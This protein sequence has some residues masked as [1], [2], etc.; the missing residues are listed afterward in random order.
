[1]NM[2]RIKGLL[3]YLTVL[4]LAAALAAPWAL[5]MLKPTQPVKTVILDKT[6][7]DTSYR[8]HKG[9]MWLLN[10]KKVGSGLGGGAYRYDKD[11]YGFYPGNDKVFRVRD[12]PADLGENGTDLLY[13]TDAY[14]VYEE[15]FTGAN[16]SG[17]RSKS[18]YGGMTREDAAKLRSYLAADRPS[19]LVA[20]FNTFGSPTEEAVREELYELL[21]VRWTG[22][23]GRYI[24]D[25]QEGGEA[26]GWAVD[27]YERQTGREWAFRG[28]GFLFVD[29]ADRVLV[30]EEGKDTGRGGLTIGFTGEGQA[31]TGL[32]G[33]YYYNYWFDV[34]EPLSGGRTLAE[35][36]LDATP[37]GLAKLAEQGIPAVFP[38]V[39]RGSSGPHATYYF[40]GDYADKG[41]VPGYYQ[42]EGLARLKSWLT[43]DRR[44]SEE[45]F[46]WK[47]Y[48]PLMD[49]VIRE[50][51]SRVEAFRPAPPPEPLV[52]GGVKLAARTS[53]Q[54]LQVYRSGSWA[55]YFV[56]GVNMGMARPGQ[57]FTELPRD[58]NVYYRWLEGIGSMNANTVR[59]YTLMPPEFY[60]A[61]L[62]YNASHGDR[63]LLL[64]Q[65]IWPEES[66]E[67]MNVLA[68]AYMAEYRKE[69]EA[70]VDAVHGR[71]DIPERKGRAYGKYEAD[72]SAYVLAYLVGRELEPDEV[73]GTDAKNA[74]YAFN[75]TYL[76][77]EG[78]S[79]SEAWLAASMDHALTYE[80]DRYGWQ[81]PVAL[82]SWP[83][84]DPMEHDSEWNP[85]GKKEL[86]F[87]DSAVIDIRHLKAGPGLR[88]GL[89]GAYHIYPNYP[90]F[91]NNEAQYDA[92][93][94]EEGR[95]R[96]GGYLQELM[97]AHTGYPA[98]V[99]EFGLATGMGNA[100]TSPDG[101]NHGGLT[102]EEQGRGIVRMMKAIRQEGYAGGVVFEWMDEW[103]KKTWVT[104]P[105][106]IPY[107]RHAVWHNMAD[108]EQNYGLL[109]MESLKPGPA[110]AA[111]DG[112]GA[113]RRL[114]LRGDA[115][116][117][118]MDVTL[119]EPYNP[120]RT[121][122]LLG[123]DTLDRARGERY[124]LDSRVEAPSAM[125]FTVVIRGAGNSK[126]L[127]IPSYN[128]TN[129]K[130]SPGVSEQGRFEEMK[131]LI[132][133]MR[134]ARDGRV[135]PMDYEAS[136]DLRYGTLDDSTHQWYAEGN[137]VHVR[138]P[139]GRLNVTDPSR[140]T[141][142]DDPGRYTDIPGRDV[143]RTAASDGVAVSA[144]LR[145]P[146]MPDLLGALPDTG[147][148]EP[149]VLPWKPWD[150][151]L[152]R[153]RLKGSVP[154][155]RDY[156]GTLP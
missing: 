40:S 54:M 79:P 135:F 14:G 101:Y 118:Y 26:P 12:L 138:I 65:E 20:E 112:K 104:E 116:Y 58:V 95:L 126:L 127:V 37:E 124:Y 68:P 147:S 32:K 23:I 149:L 78:A 45:A 152:Y 151:P 41:T 142:L 10:H 155:I 153:E 113:V 70:A 36:K 47:V 120:E 46:F 33:S 123:I 56:K 8:E 89:F 91:M 73:R 106:M 51:H 18:L 83:T 115:S 86:E 75:G 44:G 150:R 114:E 130:F 82:V 129:L 60:R 156:F 38:A 146:G 57:W 96:Y 49:G 31:L 125:E 140:G 29:D 107:D 121:E 17:N 141:V 98:L 110:G 19:T 139:W 84:L 35:Y 102:E 3:P 85:Q 148:H 81:H 53:G 111:L 63:P 88:T 39:I 103:A 143:L 77:T 4:L 1:M 90:D 2:K 131:T 134:V 43:P 145:S 108:P 28:P 25:L 30:L 100:H 80:A 42:Y 16:P 137:Q 24:P 6:V 34:V 72:V 71:A 7:P 66:P 67:G 92:Y 99:A 69:I 64:L 59:V 109:A 144:A 74:G 52:E 128:R 61:L 13:V 21:R 5:W 62:S 105:F 136:G 117:L 27:N 76:A 48:A 93:R 9:L 97:A 50:L 87:N 22:W 55:D 119:A 154:V 11:Y 94:D 133:K 132:N 122:L 15:E